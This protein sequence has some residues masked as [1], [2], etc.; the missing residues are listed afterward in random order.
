MKP[1]N[2]EQFLSLDQMM[3][4]IIGSVLRHHQN[5]DPEDKENIDET[6]LMLESQYFS[7]GAQEKIYFVYFVSE[8]KKNFFYVQRVFK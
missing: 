3:N 5:I 1:K 8:L 7:D 6:I 4:K 2:V